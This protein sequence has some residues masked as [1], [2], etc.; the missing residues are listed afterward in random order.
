[1]FRICTGS[2]SEFQ[3]AGPATVR[4]LSAK[5]VVVPQSCSALMIGDGNRYSDCTCHSGT[6]ELYRVFQKK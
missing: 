3:A 5:R 1:M 2:V 6:R 4:E